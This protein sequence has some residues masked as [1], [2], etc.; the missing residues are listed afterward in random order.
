MAPCM[1]KAIQVVF[2]AERRGIAGDCCCFGV[3]VHWAVRSPSDGLLLGHRAQLCH[4]AMTSISG[5]LVPLQDDRHSFVLA[6][7]TKIFK[8]ILTD[9]GRV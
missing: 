7:M 4:P 2:Q 5:G 9:L 6:K 1:R 8:A 3:F